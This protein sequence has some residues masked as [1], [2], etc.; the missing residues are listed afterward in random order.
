MVERGRL[1]KPGNFA[2]NIDGEEASRRLGSSNAKRAPCSS[3]VNASFVTT[4]SSHPSPQPLSLL[5][6]SN[7]KLY[8]SL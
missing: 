4:F 7:M 3:P 5:Q 8:D 2:D 6:L 1:D